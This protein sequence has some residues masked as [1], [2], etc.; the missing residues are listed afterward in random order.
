MDYKK[1]KVTASAQKL[2]LTDLS[3]E[4][5]N[6]YES[7]VI[8]GKRANQI[9]SDIK[10]DL[11]EKLHEFGNKNDTLDEELE[12]REQIEI[13]RF[14]ERMPKPTMIAEQEFLDDKI[15]YRDPQDYNK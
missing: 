1:I 5:G 4:T 3:K 12:N 9:M 14:Y 6:I 8:M 11:Q 13:S 10:V 7:V 15:Y 2:N